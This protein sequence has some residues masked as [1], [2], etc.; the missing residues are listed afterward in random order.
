MKIQYIFEA[1]ITKARVNAALRYRRSLQLGD[2]GNWW[3]FPEEL[4]KPFAF[5][6]KCHLPYF[7]CPVVCKREEAYRLR[8]KVCVK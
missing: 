5:C 3:V 6:Q 7:Q 8:L 1:R 2:K 4:V